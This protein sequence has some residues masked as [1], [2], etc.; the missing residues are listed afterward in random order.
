MFL[1]TLDTLEWISST[2]SANLSGLFHEDPHGH[3]CKV[4]IHVVDIDE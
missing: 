3:L 2:P 4:V 1:N